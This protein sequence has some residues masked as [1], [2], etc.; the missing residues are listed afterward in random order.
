MKPLRIAFS[1]CSGT[2][3]TTL[4]T[5]AAK[6]FDVPFCPVTARSFARELG[7]LSL[8]DADEAGQRPEVQR[9]FFLEKRAWELAHYDTG[10]V[11]ER[12]QF[13]ELAYGVLHCHEVYNKQWMQDVV[14]AQNRY[15]H[16]FVLPKASFQDLERDPAR[17][18][19]PTYHH[20]FECVLRGLLSDWRED[21]DIERRHFVLTL[22]EGDLAERK[23]TISERVR[24]Y[25]E[26][27]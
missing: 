22:M 6:E 16:V 5:W 3:K 20:L 24:Q 7:F 1:G 26:R 18:V 2:G 11:T 27:H 13:D 4:S 8:Y 12:S 19:D 17:K 15:T 25:R 9:R 23:R 21:L 10:F 14:D